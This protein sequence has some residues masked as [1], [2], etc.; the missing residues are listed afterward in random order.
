MTLLAL[1]LFPLSHISSFLDLTTCR[2]RTIHWYA[3]QLFDGFVLWTAFCRQIGLL[4][5]PH[6][7]PSSKHKN[8]VSAQ[9]RTLFQ[10]MGYHTLRGPDWAISL[11][12]FIVLAMFPAHHSP[13]SIILWLGCLFCF[14][15][16]LMRHVPLLVS[17]GSSSISYVTF[18]IPWPLVGWNSFFM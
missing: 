8:E 1:L 9:S 2:W 10:V 13:L 15:G 3:L 12:H 6:L 17:H 18:S 11:D 7:C 4:R 16:V 14:V 5:F